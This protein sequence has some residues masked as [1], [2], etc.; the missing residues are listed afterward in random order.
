MCQLTAQIVEGR[1]SSSRLRPRTRRSARRVN[2]AVSSHLVQGANR[3]ATIAPVRG[4]PLWEMQASRP[5]AIDPQAQPAADYQFDQ[6]IAWEDPP[7]DA[8]LSLV[9]GRSRKRPSSTWPLPAKSRQSLPITP[10]GMLT[11]TSSAWLGSAPM[12]WPRCSID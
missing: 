4:P 5:G 12:P 3:A 2:F 10:P 8:T 1:R 9:R 6:R 7:D 11:S